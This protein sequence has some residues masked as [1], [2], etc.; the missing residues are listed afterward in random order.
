MASYQDPLQPILDLV[1]DLNTLQ[2]GAQAVAPLTQDLN[3]DLQNLETALGVP[4]KAK[5]DLSDLDSL[6]GD[7]KD[8]VEVLSDIEF[9]EFL[10]IMVEPIKALQ[11]G[12]GDAVDALGD[13]DDALSPIRKTASEFQTPVN[14]VN[15]VV[16]EL[17]AQMGTWVRQLMIIDDSV[18][19]AQGVA[20]LV[21]GDFSQELDKVIGVYTGMATDLQKVVSPVTSA[22]GTVKSDIQSAQTGFHDFTSH[23][24]DVVDIAGKVD[25]AFKKISFLKPILHAIHDALKPVEWAFKAIA[26]V[27]KKVVKPILDAVIPRSFRDEIKHL[28]EKL[29]DIS[30]I[31]TAVQ[32]AETFVK[33]Q[34]QNLTQSLES[35]LTQ[36]KTLTGQNATVIS[37]LDQYLDASFN[38]QL[39]TLAKA[40]GKAPKNGDI[41]I[42]AYTTGYDHF[43]AIANNLLNLLKVNSNQHDVIVTIDGLLGAGNALLSSNKGK[44]LDFRATPHPGT[45][46]TAPSADAVAFWLKVRSYL[47]TIQANTTDSNVLAMV[48]GAI[49]TG[50]GYFQ[51][52]S[53]SAE[54]LRFLP[55]PIESGDSTM[56]PTDTQSSTGT[57]S[58]STAHFILQVIAELFPALQSIF[59]LI[60]Q[61]LPKLKPV[62]DGF[63]GGLGGVLKGEGF[64]I[65]TKYEAD[66]PA[67][68]EYIIQL[69]NI[70]PP[71]VTNPGGTSFPVKPV[72]PSTALTAGEHSDRGFCAAWPVAAVA[73]RELE[74]ILKNLN[75]LP[76]NPPSKEHIEL[77]QA[78]QVLLGIGQQIYTLQCHPGS[79]SD[80]S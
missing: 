13:L 50:N 75:T 7:I 2:K 19:L 3:T 65:N 43:W 61:K 37:T 35:L 24:S 28:F 45:V 10:D 27:F 60:G 39:A 44:N 67:K 36:A 49:G 15:K 31:Q 72:P 32:D 80:K 11:S 4:V 8:L 21:E 54:T 14:D 73:L 70:N 58:G 29:L 64:A 79:S 59:T 74:E 63:V 33:Q 69:N 66:L 68:G 22:I 17:E 62:L 40:L 23:F 6:L 41:D 46:T 53:S 16:T 34:T 26:C 25:D 48:D 77:I 1:G 18:Q 57:P 51:T 42:A 52:Q 5:T 76:P 47:Q 20:L 56:Y 78:I 55:T 38:Q 9:L 30:G 12:I 71:T